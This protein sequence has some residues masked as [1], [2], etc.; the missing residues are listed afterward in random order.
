M[1]KFVFVTPKEYEP[2][3]QELRKIIQAV[4]KILKDWRVCTFN[5]VLIGSGEQGLVTNDIEGNKGFDFDFNLDIVKVFRGFGTC[6][7]EDEYSFTAKDLKLAFIDAFDEALKGTNYEHPKD[8]TSVI[9]IKVIDFKKSKILYGADFA[10]I[11]D[12]EIIKHDK[13]AKSYYFNAKPNGISEYDKIQKIKK[14]NLWNEYRARYL[15]KKNSDY[16]KKSS[17]IRRE[18]TNDIWTKYYQ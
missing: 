4:H 10:I 17:S 5:D 3:L 8:S 11:D 13:K 2:V 14:D 18:T 1:S 12:G 6:D 15:E 7:E 16:T 9:T